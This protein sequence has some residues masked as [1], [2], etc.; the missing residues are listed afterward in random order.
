MFA[1]VAMFN[2][3]Q[4]GRPVAP[5]RRAVGKNVSGALRLGLLAIGI[6]IGTA[7]SVRQAD[8][9]RAWLMSAAVHF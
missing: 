3:A 8:H 2:C 9:A 5:Y 1:R 6:T 4:S 7:L